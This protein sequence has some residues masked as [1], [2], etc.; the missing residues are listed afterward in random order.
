MISPWFSDAELLSQ[1]RMFFTEEER[2]VIDFNALLGQIT[3]V[4]DDTGEIVVLGR[5]FRFDMEVCD[6]TEV[7]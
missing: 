4:D 3:M 1:L 5:T 2:E 7:V 6:V